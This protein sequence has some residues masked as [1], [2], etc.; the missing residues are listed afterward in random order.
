MAIK[1]GAMT[2]RVAKLAWCALLVSVLN[3]PAT[4]CQAATGEKSQATSRLVTLAAAQFPN[5]TKAE[6]TLLW[7][8]DG[9]NI[10]RGEIAVAGLSS[11]PADPSNDPA[12]ADKLETQRNVRAALIR[13]MCAEHRAMDL[14]DPKGIRVIG[15]R[16][17]GSLDLAHVRVP[18][19]LELRNCSIPEEISLDSAEL[20]ELNLNGSH[21]GAIWAPGIK[22]TGTLHMGN[23]FDALA[24]VWLEDA[25][26]DADAFFDGGRFHHSIA[27][28]E[29]PLRL[30][31]FE[32]KF[33]ITLNMDNAQ[34]KGSVFMANGFQSEGA[35]LMDNASISGDFIGWG[36]H[37]INPNN[38]AIWAPASV[39]SHDVVLSDIILQTASPQIAEVNG[40]VE[41]TNAQIGGGLDVVGVKFLGAPSDQHGLI[42]L[43][44]SIKELLTRDASFT[45]DAVENLGG[46]QVELI[47]DNAVSWPKHGKLDISGLKYQGFGAGSPVDVMSRLQWLGRN[48]T[49]FDPQPYDQLAK[50]Y[51][52]V[53]DMNSATQVLIARDDAIYSHS[54][55]IRRGWGKFLKI[56]IG[57]GHRP[58]LTVGWMLGVVAIGW[59]MVAVGKRA[60]V[61]RPTWPELIPPTADE[62]RYERLHPLLYSFDVFLPFVNFHQEHYWWPDAD[63]RGEWIV[64]GRKL[65]FSGSLLRY[66]LWAQITAGWLLSA[67]FL[68][69]VTGLIRND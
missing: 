40:L 56:T 23:G 26:I 33:K 52:S 22:V 54:D 7:F 38:F 58:L 11:N 27:P 51:H 4:L 19:P 12:H 50:Y 13:W 45:A 20:P 69:G 39:I 57:Y 29:L 61:M 62:I 35:I 3:T 16:I 48:A 68:A 32:S 25:K 44:A 14:E 59:M 46:A 34:I 30:V 5:L 21:A 36:A 9:D 18:V 10:D 43:S 55:R 67:I 41:F 15:A 8:V 49:S 24:E 31:E 6:R 17:T 53:G 66:Y 47:Y 63:R 1:G 64:F 37:F 65:R 28:R 42:A 2:R 60:G